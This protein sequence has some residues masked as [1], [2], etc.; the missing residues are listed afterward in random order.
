MGDNEIVVHGK[1]P[2]GVTGLS[3]FDFKSTKNNSSKR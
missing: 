3:S 2:I 1:Q